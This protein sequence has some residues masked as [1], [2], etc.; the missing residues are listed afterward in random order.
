MVALDVLS[1][2]TFAR[3]HGAQHI[4]LR[5]TLAFVS[6]CVAVGNAMENLGVATGFPYGRYYFAELMGPKL[7]HVPVLLGLAYIGM[8]YI[9]WTLA[10]MIAGRPDAPLAGRR[11]LA[12][13]A[14]A[15]FLMVAWDLA[16][17]PVW[18]TVLHGWIWL[19]GGSWFGV[20]VSNYFGW[21]LTVFIIY[22][23]FAFSLR[24]KAASLVP[25]RRV[26]RYT[27]V[28]FYAACALGNI[29]Q[30]IP[31]PNPPMVADAAGRQWRVADITAASALV[32]IFA[33]G[34][35]AVM[36][37]MRSAGETLSAR[38]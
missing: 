36:A 15:S 14:V 35:F 10:T 19:D 28:L 9:S 2:M 17:D 34:A 27:A 8:A 37:W 5:S 13:P 20:P 32:S 18:A 7:F 21:Y 6:I 30:T 33:M 16:Q 38:D 4:G 29:L 3:V 1:A 11:L 22:L 24:R 31:A 26:D 23:L 25:A 12:V